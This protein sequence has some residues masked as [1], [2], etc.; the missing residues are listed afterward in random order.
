MWTVS[1][2]SGSLLLWAVSYAAVKYIYILLWS[3]ILKWDHFWQVLEGK[4]VH[5]KSSQSLPAL[6]SLTVVDILL[7]FKHRPSIFLKFCMYIYGSLY[8]SPYWKKDQNYTNFAVILFFFLTSVFSYWYRIVRIMGVTCA[9]HTE[10]GALRLHFLEYQI[11][12][13]AKI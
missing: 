11:Q 4:N 2:L 8:Q 6:F 9:S 7:A 1:R 13:R 3:C 10:I 12:W 5:G